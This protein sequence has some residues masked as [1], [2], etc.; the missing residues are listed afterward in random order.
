MDFETIVKKLSPKLKGI[1]RRLNGHFSFFDDDDLFQEALGHLW[2]CFQQGKLD[3]KTDSYILQGCFFYLKNY[4]RKIIDKAKMISLDGLTDEDGTRLEKYFACENRAFRDDIDTS[5]L[6]Q[7]A[8]RD[9]LTEREQL[10]LTLLLDGF[11]VRDIGKKLG[12]SHVMV[13]K[14]KKNIK[15]K[16][17]IFKYQSSGSYQN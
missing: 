17:M 12:T 10:V 6:M 16:Y 9:G 7:A 13:I 5:L 8:K 4:L 2:V 15:K 11:T 1:A 14:L 3:N